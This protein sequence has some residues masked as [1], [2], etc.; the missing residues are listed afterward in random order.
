M[1]EFIRTHQ[2]L[3][4]LF[5]LLLIIPSFVLVSGVGNNFRELDTTVAKIGKQAISQQEFEN[6]QREQMNRFRQM[7]GAQF[8][9]K[10]FDTPEMKQR[11]LDGLIEQ[12]VLAA[13]V[14]EKHLRASDEAVKRQLAND[15]R[16][17]GVD[18]KI[19][20]ARFA[21]LLASNNYNDRAYVNQ[22]RSDLSLQQL[23]QALQGSAFA[24][25]TIAARISDIRDQEREVQELMF[26][27]ADF[28]DKAQVSDKAVNDYYKNNAKQYEMPDRIKA[29]YIVLNSDVVEQ[30]VT[31]SDAEAKTFYDANL[32]RFAQ[33]EQRRTSHILVGL[34]K[35]A[36]AGDKAAAKT[37]AEGLLAQARKNPLEFAK[38]AKEN[39]DDKG[40]AANGGDMDYFGGGIKDYDDAAA[41]LKKGEISEPV[42]SDAGYHI[43]MVTELKPKVQKAF[44]EVKADIVAEL[45]KPLISKKLTEMIGKF[46]ES[47]EDHG[48]ALK[49][50]ADALKLKIETVDGLM[51]NPNPGLP[52]TVAYNNVKFLTA[53]FADDIVKGKR[54]TLAIEVTP[55]VL[56]AGHVVDYKPVALRPFAEV[57]GVIRDQLVRQEADKLASAAGAAKLAALKTTPDATGFAE[58]TKVSHTKPS[59]YNPL[60]VPAVMKAD[61]SKLPAF[62]GVEVPGMGYAVYRINKVETPATPDAARRQGEQQQIGNMLAAQEMRGFIDLLKEKA[63]VKI[64]KPV[65]PASASV[66]ASASAASGK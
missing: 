58:A 17:L 62:V 14:E 12:K 5:L 27:A 60:A 38:L 35:D 41:K 24:P 59:T 20:D 46:T 33:A 9:P 22:V 43:I 19:D 31:V 4:Q 15:P 66:S 34:K 18:G 55:G 39:S 32:A 25:K 11:M 61:T 6:V 56:I 42:L 49:P 50:T 21:A 36:S 3:M 10:M 63:K 7:A 48:D 28:K 13:M 29:E 16:L 23:G 44:D 51:R 53:L 54:N 64:I 2:R 40:S 26:K 30:Q 65:V 47:V 57:Q 1:F 8:D 45:K 52:P 37:K